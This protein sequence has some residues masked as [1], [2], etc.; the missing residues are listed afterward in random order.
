MRNDDGEWFNWHS[1]LQNLIKEYF[2]RLFTADQTQGDVVLN[3]ITQTVL[4]QQNR[5]LLEAVSDEEVKDTVFHMHPDKAPGPDG[6]TLAFF[7]KNWSV[8]GEEVIMMV[9]NFFATGV[10]LENINSTNIVLIP[11][12]RN[13]SRLTELR[14]IALCNVVM[15]V[16]T[17]VISNRLKSVLDSVISDTQSA[18]LPGKLITDNACYDLF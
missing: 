6:M 15:K 18:F 4:E 3:C 12:K 5:L 13:P 2:Q 1:G 9:R 17:K 11:K 7:Q 16:I 8:V 14:P 10:L